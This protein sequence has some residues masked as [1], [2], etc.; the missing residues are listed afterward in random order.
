MCIQ[1]CLTNTTEGNISSQNKIT[2]YK[3]SVSYQCRYT[4]ISEYIVQLLNSYNASGLLDKFEGKNFTEQQ[5]R[6]ND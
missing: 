3:V 2:V 4:T 6:L 1:L 5:V